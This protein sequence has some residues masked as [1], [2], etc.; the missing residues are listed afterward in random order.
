MPTARFEADFS[1]FISAIDQSKIALVNFN[2]G[3]QD[4]EKTL[5]AMTGPIQRAPARFKRPR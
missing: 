4:V 2:T 1:G 3:A 5:N